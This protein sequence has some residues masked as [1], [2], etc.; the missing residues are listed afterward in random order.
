M[1]YAP[2][3][4]DMESINDAVA[5]IEHHMDNINDLLPGIP[6][7]YAEDFLTQIQCA[8]VSLE[9]AHQYLVK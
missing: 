7:E 5:N 9:A 3:H 8:E 1:H 4:V 6:E 2:E